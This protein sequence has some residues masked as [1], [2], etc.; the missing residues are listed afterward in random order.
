MPSLRYIQYARRSSE[1]RSN[2]QLKSIQGQDGA[3]ADLALQ[4]SL[5]VV[6]NLEESRTAKDPGRPI[7]NDMLKKIEHGKADAILCWHL[8]RLTRNEIDSGKL[9]WMLRKGIIKE[10][11]TP[12]RVYLPGDSLLITAVESAIGEQ[13]I[14]DLTHKVNRGMKLKCQNGEIPFKAPQGYLNNRLAKKV[15]IDPER[16]PLIQKIFQTVLQKS[17]SVAEIHRMMHDEWGYHKRAYKNSTTHELSLNAL[18]QLLSNPFYAGCFSWQGEMYTHNLPCVVTKNDFDRVQEILGKRAQKKTANRF[19][20]SG[21]IHCAT[22][23]YCVTAEVAKGHTY[24]HC[25]NRFGTCTKKG[26]R[27]EKLE[28]EIDDLLKTITIDPIFEGM[29]KEVLSDL[30]QAESDTTQALLESQQKAV[31]DVKR[32]KDALLNLFLQ[33]HLSE[34]EYAEKKQ[35]LSQREINSNLNLSQADANSEGCFQTI[36]N[37]AKFATTARSLFMASDAPTK[38]MIASA[39]GEEYLLAH[40][41]ISIELNPLFVPVRTSFK[42]LTKNLKR[43]EP[44]KNRSQNWKAAIP[45]SQY[46]VWQTT[47]CQYRK[48]VC[49]HNADFQFSWKKGRSNS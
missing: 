27:E 20:Y 6:Q 21:L 40:G 46:H 14:V 5:D 17:H 3:L 28:E 38:R 13:F 1:E 25:S 30:R 35:E 22:C 49:T 47:L 43:F 8:D 16:F 34:A 29:V 7:F 10:I 31:A 44:Q 12:H 37:M 48:N 4:L 2:K 18:H 15:E 26:I 42:K 45:A 19:A 32:Q 36:E 39:L 33:G 24:Y 11:R 23:G 9:R 41:E